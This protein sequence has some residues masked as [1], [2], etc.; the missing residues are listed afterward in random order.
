MWVM[1]PPLWQSLT[2]LF[3]ICSFSKSQVSPTCSRKV[4]TA[5]TRARPPA[6]KRK[7]RSVL[8]TRE[9]KEWVS[10]DND[11][12]KK[13]NPPSSS[14][15]GWNIRWE[16]KITFRAPVL[17]NNIT[18]HFSFYSRNI[19]VELT[20]RQYLFLMCLLCF[21]VSEQLQQR[22]HRLWGVRGPACWRR[23]GAGCGLQHLNVLFGSHCGFLPKSHSRRQQEEEEQPVRNS[24]QY[25]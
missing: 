7:R 22:Q 4:K 16:I 13:K 18:F 15:N 5:T 8:S 25:K 1:W 11:D 20:H 3:S 2:I 21:V 17:L 12:L 24:L 19:T 9:E 10:A 6:L 23:A 14:C